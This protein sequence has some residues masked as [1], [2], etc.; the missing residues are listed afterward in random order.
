VTESERAHFDDLLGQVIETLPEHIAAL[1]EEVPVIVDDRPD[2]VL[3]A[4]LRALWQVEQSIPDETF[5]REICGLH[6]GNMLTER[7]VEDASDLPEQIHLFRAGILEEAR[8]RQSAS[9][10]PSDDQIYEEIAVTLL[11]EIG[12]HFGLDE[13]DLA[14]LGYN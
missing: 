3:L 14:E 8:C 13:D 7:S 10:Q 5:A 9:A 11:H 2:P 12:H 1:I 4:E 6:T